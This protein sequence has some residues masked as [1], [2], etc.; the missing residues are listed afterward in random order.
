[1]RMKKGNHVCTHEVL[2][3]CFG[4]ETLQY[5]RCYTAAFTM[6]WP[7]S[8]ALCR[9]TSQ[10]AVRT[11][12]LHHKH[13]GTHVLSNVEQHVQNTVWLVVGRSSVRDQRALEMVSQRIRMHTAIVA[14]T[15]DVSGWDRWRSS[16]PLGD[17]LCDS[18]PLSIGVFLSLHEHGP[19]AHTSNLTSTPGQGFAPMATLPSPPL[20]IRFRNIF[21]LNS[22]QPMIQH[23]YLPSKLESGRS[24][25]VTLCILTL[26][27]CR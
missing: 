23:A 16:A 8:S 6:R 24:H 17:R 15:L 3:R 4:C 14:K 11:V 7:A 12:R 10:L 27:P 22:L 1:M 18:V 26:N 19:P 25:A 2:R 20:P 9:Q 21:H 5:R 13:G